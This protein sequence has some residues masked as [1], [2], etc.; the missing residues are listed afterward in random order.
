[1]DCKEEDLEQQNMRR[2]AVIAVAFSTVA[3]IA[4][5]ITLP[6]MHIYVQSL[7]SH[8]INEV[9]YCKSRSR[10]MLVEMSGLQLANVRRFKREWMFGRW[11]PTV[12]PSNNHQEHE[13]AVI[14]V[15]WNSC[16]TCN[17]GAAG[18]PGPEGD[19]G[20]NGKDGMNGKDGKNG[21]DAHAKPPLHADLCII[22]PPG[23][24]GPPGNMGPK[25]P[26]GPKG[27]PGDP[28]KDG[29]N[30]EMGTTG[31]PGAI[32]RPGRTGPPGT[33]GSP[34]RIIYMTGPQGPPGPQ[35]L[36][37]SPGPKGI[38]GPDGQSFPGPPGLPG[39]AGQ[40]GP[41]GRPGKIGQRGV[42]GEPGELGTCNHCPMPRILHLDSGSTIYRLIL[43]P[44]T[45][46]GF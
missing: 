34:G 43:A 10:N 23:R 39:D 1:M 30:G 5:V 8:V 41:E 4:T 37:G 29:I 36:Q 44:R 42:L 13:D 33:R 20:D 17:Q 24:P 32:G 2:L 15:E 14:N 19:E 26:P 38:P 11:V 27:T 12:E 18:P 25:G 46:S 45:P 16:C 22:C 21:V 40:P 35:G 3:V 9:D 28:P 6:A 7:H 31:Q